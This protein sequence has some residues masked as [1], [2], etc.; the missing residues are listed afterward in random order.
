MLAPWKESYDNP[1]QRIK[2][3]RHPCKGPGSQTYG[4]PIVMYECDS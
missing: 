4:F 2:K 1:R 3:Q